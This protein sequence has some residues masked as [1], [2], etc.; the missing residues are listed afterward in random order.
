MTADPWHY[1]RQELAKHVLGM[2]ESGLS[3]ALVFFAPRRMGKTE[4]LSKDIGPLAA[5]A[6]WKVF[7]FSFLD[8]GMNAA[9]EFTKALIHFSKA[10]QSAKAA[11]IL[12]RV[13]KLSAEV[14]GVKAEI[15][16][17]SR[18]ENPVAIKEVIEEICKKHKL[19]LL[20]D[21]VQTLTQDPANANF[22]ASLRTVLDMNKGNVKVIFT[23]SSQEGLRRMFS[24]AR[25][26]FFHFG[27][28]LP[29]P[30]LDRGF[31]DHL[32]NMFEKATK[33]K[34]DKEALWTHFVNMQKVPQLARALVERVALNPQLSLD[35]S[36]KQLLLQIFDD[37]AFVS[38]WNQSSSLEKLLL[39]D[40]SSGTSS[41]FS[42]ETR[43]K[44][45]K[46]LGVDEITTTSVQSAIRVLKRKLLIG[47]VPEQRNYY[48]DDPNFKNWLFT[49][50]L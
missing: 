12:K 17:Q 40:I 39:K 30:E 5:K 41:P 35:E 31:T 21:E 3:S 25:A 50:K 49:L 38:V 6:K 42:Q 46:L 2:F 4:F 36:K 44:Y 29:F 13:N 11:G 1:P 37:R 47:S 45:T 28:N 22:I 34:L 27:Q 19:L 23:G 7:Y 24:Q 48:I 15:Q 26:P 8:V 14:I 20:M 32:A 18:I 43:E 10:Q 9:N 16:L 33:R